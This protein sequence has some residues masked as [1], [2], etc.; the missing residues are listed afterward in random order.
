MRALMFRRPF[1]G[2]AL[3]T[4]AAVVLVALIALGAMA[5]PLHL[6]GDPR[7]IGVGPRLAPPAASWPLGT[8]AFGRSTL[9]RVLQGIGATFLLA[10][11][12]VLLTAVIA[13]VVGMIAGFVRGFPDEIIVRVADVLFSFPAILLAIMVSAI[14]GPGKPAAVI[15]IVLITMPLMLRVVRATTLVVAERDFVLA[16]EVAGAS[17]GR[18]LFVHI[19]PNIAGAA[20]VQAT[21][22]VS[23][24]MLVESALSFLGLGVQ[25]PDASLGS[26]LREGNV[27]LVIAPWLV[28]AP[29]IILALTILSVNLV[30]DGLRDALDP[31]E[32]RLLR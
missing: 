2:D 5:A 30:G 22:A 3:S 8:D 24:G 29:G 17:L 4:F 21:Y 31:R 6:G 25:P 14:L 18:L 15:S 11:T 12:A 16:S 10:T 7:A 20:A 19:L 28:F 23:V 9:P 27:Y 13:V 1:R 32:A 26:L